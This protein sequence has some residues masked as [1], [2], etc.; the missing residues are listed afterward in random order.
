MSLSIAIA[1]IVFADLAMLG[2][3]ACVMSRAKLLT[4]HVSVAA[5]P[6]RTPPAVSPARPAGHAL[7]ARAT[8]LP[9]SA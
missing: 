6:V 3:L 4:S 7:R 2:M 1:A 8:A 9:V 5:A